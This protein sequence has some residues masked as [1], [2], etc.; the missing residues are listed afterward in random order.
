MDAI[1]VRTERP[2]DEEAIRRVNDQAFGQTDESRIVDAVRQ[3]GHAAVSLVAV[4]GGRV[5]GHI[6]F[7][8]VSIESQEADGLAVA[9]GPMSVLPDL[10]RRGIGTRLVR[11]GLH[12]CARIGGRVVV[13][14]GHP[15]FY[16]RFGFRPASRFELRSNYDVP[17]DVFMAVELQPGA[18]SGCKGLV[19]FVAEFGSP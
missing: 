3:A 4:D 5:V 12:A 15:G 10:Q 1:E 2:G 14:I 9:L 6:L 7:T 13:V 16:P 17:D 11:A 19:R 8:P 18:L